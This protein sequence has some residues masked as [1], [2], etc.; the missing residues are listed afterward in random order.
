MVLDFQLRDDEDEDEDDDEYVLASRREAEIGD[1]NVLRDVLSSRW[2]ARV[3][4]IRYIVVVADELVE[5][6]KR[7][8]KSPASKRKSV[9]QVDD[10]AFRS[11]KNLAGFRKL[12][13]SLLLFALFQ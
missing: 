4:T 1:G 2:A 3:L 7:S 12:P 11:D 8:G 10:V 9:A 6:V 5:V 13:P